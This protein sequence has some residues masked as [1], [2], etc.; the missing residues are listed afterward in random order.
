M[1]SVFVPA[2][3]ATMPSDHTRQIEVWFAMVVGLGVI[4]LAVLF[5]QV[6]FK[7]IEQNIEIFFLVVGAFASAVS[8][9]WGSKLLRAAVTEPIALTAAVLIF[10]LIVRLVRPWLDRGVERLVEVV[11]P[12]WGYLRLIVPLRLLSSI[13]TAVIACL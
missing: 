6:M 7:P 9:Q 4:L 2:N 5:G 8:G 11:Q 13:I 10:G 12:R 1:S 3:T